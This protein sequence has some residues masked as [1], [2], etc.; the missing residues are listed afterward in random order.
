MESRTAALNSNHFVIAPVNIAT[1]QLCVAAVLNE[2]SPTLRLS[3]LR[4]MYVVCGRLY[5]LYLSVFLNCCK[6]PWRVQMSMQPVIDTVISN[7]QWL[8]TFTHWAVVESG[9]VATRGHCWSVEIPDVPFCKLD[10]L[11]QLFD[12]SRVR[13]LHFSNLRLRYRV[14]RRMNLKPAV[15]DGLIDCFSG[16]VCQPKMLSAAPNKNIVQCFYTYLFTYFIY[17]FSPSVFNSC[18]TNIYI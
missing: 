2:S 1:S 5:L 13:W 4:C 12:Y 7:V 15:L 3:V 11:P 16:C 17:T 10:L 18:H 8:V 6:L 9:V 14:R